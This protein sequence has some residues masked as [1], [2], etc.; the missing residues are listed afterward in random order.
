MNKKQQSALRTRRRIVATA[1]SIISDEGVVALTSR[2]LIERAGLSKGALY[3]HFDS[4]DDVV[5][6]VIMEGEGNS[7]FDDELQMFLNDQS[8]SVAGFL[9]YAE[10]RLYAAISGKLD[11]S[12]FEAKVLPKI[13]TNQYIRMQIKK[14]DNEWIEKTVKTISS[15]QKHEQCK[16]LVHLISSTASGMVFK[17]LIHRDKEFVKAQWE[18]FKSMVLALWV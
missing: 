2:N 10:K 9:E 13:I 8:P 3:H 4:L 5:V 14:K 17:H 15:S 6:A 7:D 12:L 1:Q 11:R 16:T 18:M